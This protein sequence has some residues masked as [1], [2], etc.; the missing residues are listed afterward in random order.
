MYLSS[1]VFKI[2]DSRSVEKRDESNDAFESP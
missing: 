2:S 1:F